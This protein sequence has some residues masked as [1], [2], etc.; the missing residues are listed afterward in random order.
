MHVLRREFQLRKLFY[1]YRNERVFYCCQ[2]RWPRPLFV[3][4]RVLLALYTVYGLVHLIVNFYV[5]ESDPREDERTLVNN[6]LVWKEKAV[7]KP[8]IVFFTVW[9]YILLMVHMGL[10]AVLS[11]VFYKRAE[12]DIT[13]LKLRPVSICEK[14]SGAVSTELSEP[15]K[16][17]PSLESQSFT[18][19]CG[20]GDNNHVVNKTY[21]PS[22]DAKEVNSMSL[23]VS[24]ESEEG[25]AA[26]KN[27][28]TASRRLSS[29]ESFR[30][31]NDES[32]SMSTPFYFQISW[33]LSDIV[34]ASAPIVTVIFFTALYPLVK[35]RP[36]EGLDLQNTNVHALNFVFVVIDHLISPRPIRLLHFAAPLIYG[37]VY[38]I[39]SV[40]Y[41]S[42][43]HVNHVIYPGVLDWNY[44]GVAV[45]V[46]LGLAVVAIPLLQLSFFALY[47]LKS[48]IH[49]R[50]YD[51][52]FN[53]DLD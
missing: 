42:T 16:T 13:K 53:G 31:F 6:T 15:R 10:A 24:V 11:I 19:N 51:C 17:S 9:S 40:I 50:L 25:G 20:V 41:W 2:W 14:Q 5:K 28:N 52:S 36:A 37:C 49:K 43:D 38:I 23:S 34:S 21:V 12:T 45:G 30:R 26:A 8:F 7:V 46:S 22:G 35:D 44:P 48:W 47:Q 4:I 39:F 18:S 1:S 29:Y 33:C 32:M 27:G 3:T